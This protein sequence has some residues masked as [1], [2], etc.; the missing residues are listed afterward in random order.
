MAIAAV[1][2]WTLR[3]ERA[4][5][6]RLAW[7]FAIS[8]CLHLLIFATYHTGQKLDLWKRLHWPAWLQS[9][10]MLT[11]LLK[12]KQAVALLP[13]PQPQVPL[14]FVD[15]SPAQ[16]VTEPP[17][18]PK[19]YS[20]RSSVAANPDAAKVA[21]VPKIDGKQTQVVRTRDVPRQTFVPLQ[22]AP[23]APPPPAPQPPQP[24]EQPE[25]KPKPASTPGDLV[26][27]KPEPIARKAEG[28]A[29][30]AKPAAPTRKNEPEA[31]EAKPRHF[32]T[33]AEAKASQRDSSLP[34]ERMKQDGGVPR[35][36]LDPGFDVAASPFGAYD[37][38]L[39]E[40]VSHR[41][42]SL[43]DRHDYVSNDRGKVV[44]HFYLHA[45]G[46]ITEL[47]V[48]EST[49]GEMLSLLCQRAIL[50]PQPFA[51]W[52]ADMRRLLGSSRSIQFTFY[53]N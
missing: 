22:P 27:A 34:G 13:P 18:N 29:T 16:A 38:A 46:S 39:I 17:K 25:E 8:L 50:D 52:P 44:L 19:G 20:D 28:D 47:T 45:D 30:A 43:L 32:R 51:A 48:A 49:V 37:R 33:V 7:A 36:A 4:E 5:T 26:M 40:A 35:R 42:Y 24:K 14:M 21:D 31:A 15:V 3:L 6:S 12:K 2:K 53:Y 9:P 11:E 23:P 41:W 1:D 10:R